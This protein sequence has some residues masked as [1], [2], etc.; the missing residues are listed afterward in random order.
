MNTSNVVIAALRTGHDSLAELV[1]SFREDDLTRPSGSAQWDVSE[2]LSH[3]GSGAEIGQATL[4]A[5]LDDKPNPGRQS[6][7]TIWDRWNAMT[8]RQRADRFLHAN[9]TLTGLYESLDASKRENLRIDMG[10][11]PAPVD[12]AT[13]AR[14]RLSELAL[15]SWDIRVAF[16]EH[17]ALA[18]E[19]TTELLHGF[20]D[21]LGW[22]S[23]PER[24]GGK[25]GVIRVTTSGPA[26]DFAL[27]LDTGISVDSTVPEKPDG[28]LALPAEAWLRLIAGRLAAPHAPAGVSTT[29]AAD[30]DL[31]RRVFPGY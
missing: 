23:K 8:R 27:R 21:M 15:H 19:A 29:G 1:S 28:A 9:N 20:S 26:S 14:L 17:A 16:D 13:A 4:Q 22:T 6:M 2:V 18:P 31:L 11:M 30:L 7:E 10:F 12:V 5:A 24:L 3:L 25:H